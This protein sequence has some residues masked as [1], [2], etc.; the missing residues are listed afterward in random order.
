MLC[1]CMSIILFML[2]LLFNIIIFENYKKL[3][4]ELQLKRFIKCTKKYFP[5]INN[6]I[7]SEVTYARLIKRKEIQ[8]STNFSIVENPKISFIS[9]VYNK[10]KYLDLLIIS[11]QKIDIND[12]E[13][14]FVD[15]CSEDKSINI[16]NNFMEHDKRIKLIKNTRNRGSLYSRSIGAINSKGDYIIFVD[17]DDIILS[18]GISN[19]YQTILEKNLSMVQ[20][21]SLIQKTDFISINRLYDKYKNII[22]QPILSYIFYF[23][24]SDIEERNSGLWDKIIKRDVV[25]KSIFFIGKKYLKSNIMIENDVILLFSL[26]QKSESYQYIND[27]GYYYIRTHNESISNNWENP[28]IAKKIVHSILNTVDFLYEKSGDSYFEKK[29]SFFKLKQSFNRYKS[30]FQYCDSDDKLIINLFDKLLNSK[31]IFSKDKLTIINIE[32]EIS[33]IQ[34]NSKYLFRNKI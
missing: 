27:I 20:Y 29:I 10:E 24:G 30:C 23:N 12:I 3:S 16:I 1:R 14:I 18:S 28:K 31:Y 33:S 17:S 19:A 6:N 26:L 34:G 5:T 21:N 7:V 4:L 25:I 22:F 2:I 32:T 13:I 8:T 9:S 15:D 11:I